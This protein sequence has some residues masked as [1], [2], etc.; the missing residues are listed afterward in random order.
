MATNSNYILG[1]TRK[2][3]QRSRK[4]AL[5]QQAIT[6]GLESDDAGELD[7]QA[8]KQQARIKLSFL[9]PEPR[10]EPLYDS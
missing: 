4:V 7:M 2:N 9:H 1:L 5:L 3:Q 8:I 6:A 10:V